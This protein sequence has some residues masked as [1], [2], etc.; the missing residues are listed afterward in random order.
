VSYDHRAELEKVIARLERGDDPTLV[1]AVEEGTGA[2]WASIKNWRREHPDLD[3]RIKGILAAHPNGG[4][5]AGISRRH[6]NPK[7]GVSKREAAALGSRRLIGFQFKDEVLTIL[8]GDPYLRRLIETT[9]KELNEEVRAMRRKFFA[10]EGDELEFLGEAKDIPAYV[11]ARKEQRSWI[12]SLAKLI[13]KESHNVSSATIEHKKSDRDRLEEMTLEE[14]A[15]YRA[16]KG[17]DVTDRS[18]VIDA[19]SRDLN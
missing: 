2:S 5:R 13:P 10:G 15:E 14:L 17:I 19:Y 4:V 12:D 11:S 7:P 16:K 3:A 1:Q 18:V 6:I 9:P 8:S